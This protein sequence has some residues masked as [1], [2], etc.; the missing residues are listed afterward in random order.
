MSGTRLLASAAFFFAMPGVAR[1]SKATSTNV[2]V[3]SVGLGM[4]VVVALG[5]IRR[6]IQELLHLNGNRLQL[7]ERIKSTNAL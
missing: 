3:V 7:L 5:V 4:L 2:S 6:G 1:V